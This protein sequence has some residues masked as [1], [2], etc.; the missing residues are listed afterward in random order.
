MF[1]RLCLDVFGMLDYLPTPILPSSGDFHMALD[2]WMGAFTTDSEVCQRLFD[3]CIPVWLVWSESTLPP[4]INVRKNV[5]LTRPTDIVMEPE[6]FNVGQVL[7][8]E[9][10]QYRGGCSRHM[11]TRR[12]PSIGIEQLTSPFAE[13]D[14]APIS[15]VVG[16]ASEHQRSSNNS[17]PAQREITSS[18]AGVVRTQR[19]NARQE[20]C[21]CSAIIHFCIYKLHGLDS[22]SSAVR[23][24]KSG[25][26][27]GVSNPVSGLW[28]D[29]DHSAIP[30]DVYSW[31]TAFQ[32]VDKDTKRVRADAPKLA[33]FFPHPALF[34]NG[35]S[36]ERRE[37]YLRTWLAS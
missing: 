28:M 1:Q 26:Q 32:D 22:R 16:P 3:A 4:D 36:K 24:R 6:E 9:R 13:G 29:P 37:R 11:W 7:K 12:A 10:V 34:V 2:C 35:D 21:R 25:R 33:Y 19:S 14:A 20:P 23:G 8:L 27:A 30:L 5:D 31:R 18:G 15:A 17:M